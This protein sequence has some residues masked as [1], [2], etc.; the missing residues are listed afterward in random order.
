[1]IVRLE[2]QEIQALAG[3]IDLALKSAGLQVA[4]SAVH[5]IAKLEAAEPEPDGDDPE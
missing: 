2:E 3:L 5:L 1:M 4:K